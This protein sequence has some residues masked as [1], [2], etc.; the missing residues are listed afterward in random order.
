MTGSDDDDVREDPHY[1][2]AVA[3][4]TV[5]LLAGLGALV[6]GAVL[7]VRLALGLVT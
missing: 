6:V 4:V 1:P 2:L 7:L 3:I 5:L